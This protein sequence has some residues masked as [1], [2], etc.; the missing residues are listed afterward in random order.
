MQSLKEWI[1]YSVDLM[2]LPLSTVRWKKAECCE[3]YKWGSHF[4]NRTDK[5]PF[6]MRTDVCI[7]TYVSLQDWNNIKNNVGTDIDKH[8]L[9]TWAM[10]F[11][12]SQGGWWRWRWKMGELCRKKKR[13]KA[14]LLK[15]I[16]NL[17]YIKLYAYMYVYT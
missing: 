5:S 12:E 9:S 2:D 4:V 6:H 8:S 16:Y 11:G 3:I 17:I 15:Y 7:R 1:S 10:M 13:K 14:N